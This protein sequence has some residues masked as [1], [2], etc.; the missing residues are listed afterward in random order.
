MHVQNLFQTIA[1]AHQKNSHMLRTQFSSSSSSLMC[2]GRDLLTA[3]KTQHNSGS[4]TIVLFD[5]QDRETGAD[6][7]SDDCMQIIPYYYL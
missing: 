6:S 2:Q 3:D 7:D 5:E 4:K 1:H